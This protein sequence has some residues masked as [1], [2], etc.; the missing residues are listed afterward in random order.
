MTIRTY[1][2][3]TLLLSLIALA[4]GGFLL[5]LRVHPFAQQ[6][7]KL[8]P[9]I[10]GVLSIVLV[11]LLF[12]FKR[13]LG[14]GYVLNGML[15]IIGTITMAHFAIA[16]W[17]KPA[18]LEAILLKTTL[19]DIALLW[20]KFFVG[21]ALFELELHGYDPNQ[22]KKGITYRYPNYGWWIVHFVVISLVY[23][24]GYLLWR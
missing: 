9:F 21:K 6:S 19:A 2:K 10:S 20:G 17:P 13:T 11:P 16:N 3:S 7:S 12:S 4:L 8:V 23:Y 15:A 1:I 18:S 14:Y 22:V 24:L 5:H